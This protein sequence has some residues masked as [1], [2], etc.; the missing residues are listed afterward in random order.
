MDA[1]HGLVA[2]SGEGRGV[3]GS[4]GSLLMC[5]D[6]FLERGGGRRLASLRLELGCG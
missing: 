6:F 3:F 1:A 2:D 4:N 5:V